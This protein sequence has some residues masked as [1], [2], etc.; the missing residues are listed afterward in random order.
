MY[1]IEYKDSW[2]KKHGKLSFC[3]VFKDQKAEEEVSFL[4]E[5]YLTDL[6]HL[7]D[8]KLSSLEHTYQI[9]KKEIK[10]LKEL[11]SELQSASVTRGETK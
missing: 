5:K 3:K 7:I 9:P 4:M 6:S 1:I 10:R 8:A 2:V 11:I